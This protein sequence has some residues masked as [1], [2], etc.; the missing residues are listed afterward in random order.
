MSLQTSDSTSVS[1]SVRATRQ[2]D[3]PAQFVPFAD[4][5]VLADALKDRAI[6]VGAQWSSRKSAVLELHTLCRSLLDERERVARKLTRHARILKSLLCQDDV[7]ETI[8]ATVAEACPDLSQASIEQSLRQLIA[9]MIEGMGE[10][11]IA[12][13][14]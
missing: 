1:S 10:V 11:R 8:V 5:R 13:V 7:H 14:S 2:A 9:V 12:A 6:E 3:A 4:A